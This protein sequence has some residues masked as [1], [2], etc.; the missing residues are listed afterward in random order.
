MI[1]ENK[2]VIGILCIV[3]I[4]ITAMFNPIYALILSAI[5]LS[6]LFSQSLS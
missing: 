4:Y 2:E 3:V 1:K 5:F 6:F